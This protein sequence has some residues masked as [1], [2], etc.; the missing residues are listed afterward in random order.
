MRSA[1][2]VWEA[3][4]GELQLQVSK[5]NYRTWF[6]GTKAIACQGGRFTI[7]VPNA[8]TAEYLDRKQRSLIEKTLLGLTGGNISVQFQLDAGPANTA[9]GTIR[10]QGN[11]QEC[12]SYNP[13]YTFESYITGSCNRMAHSAA[14]A[15]AQSPGQGYNPLFIYGGSGLG[16]T[17]L[18]QAIGNLAQANGVSVLYASGEQY[19][20]DFITAIRERKME[21]FRTK[22]RD[23][24]LL[25]IDDIHFI[26]GKEQTRTSSTPSTS[27]TTLTGR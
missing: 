19:T 3:A 11:G 1:Q 4:L 2:E 6:K 23:I 5:S 22:Y 27:C 20:N 17:H 24:D 26:G 18:L 15:A 14:L 16:K 7:S 13:K 9:T 21:E 12:S 10:Q 8:F 25:M